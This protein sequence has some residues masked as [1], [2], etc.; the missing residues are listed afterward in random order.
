MVPSKALLRKDL[1]LGTPGI[2]NVIDGMG[3]QDDIYA[4]GSENLVNV[5]PGDLVNTAGSKYRLLQ[6]HRINA[7]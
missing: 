3:G 6:L 5:H 2:V 4:D 7:Q 1:I